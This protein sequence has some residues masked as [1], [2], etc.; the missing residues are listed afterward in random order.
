MCQI[1][2]NIQGLNKQLRRCRNKRSLKYKKKKRRAIRFKSIVPIPYV[3]WNDYND[4]VTIRFDI[5]IMPYLIDLKKISR[6]MLCLM[7]WS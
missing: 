7:S 4:E 6:N 3:E 5:A 1:M 2:I